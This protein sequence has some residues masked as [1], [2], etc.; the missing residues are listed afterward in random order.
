[1]LASIWESEKRS[2]ILRLLD[3]REWPSIRRK[4]QR[5]NIKRKH[6]LYKNQHKIYK[7]YDWING[8]LLSDGHI[9]KQGRYCHTTKHKEYADFLTKKFASIKVTTSTYDDRR[10][11]ERTGN[12]YE[13][14]MLRTPSVFKSLREK[15]YPNGHKEI[16]SDIEINNESLW[17]WFLGDGSVRSGGK[18][19]YFATMGFSDR[20]LDICKLS[21]NN[22]GINVTV[23]KNR[24][25]YVL[26]NIDN[27]IIFSDMLSDDEYAPECYNYKINRLKQWVA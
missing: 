8:E 9:D 6:P 18:G 20:S 23:S 16:P 5:M 4:A 15:W 27:K 13:R 12:Y 7:E 26:K 25:L 1:M 10:L 19:F 14:T 21:L 3:G 11:E 22:L 17:H 24:C 2:E